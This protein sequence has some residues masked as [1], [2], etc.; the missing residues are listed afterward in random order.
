[1]LLLKGAD[2]GALRCACEAVLEAA[3]RVPRSV[4]VGLDARPVHML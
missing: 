1:M 3:R 4:Q 2:A